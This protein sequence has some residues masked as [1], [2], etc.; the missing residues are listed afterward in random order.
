MTI[1]TDAC[2]AS[3][4]VYRPRNPRASPLY[5]CIVHHYDEL[6]AGDHFAAQ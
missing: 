6:E 2:T 5:Q 1:S 4:G 3:S